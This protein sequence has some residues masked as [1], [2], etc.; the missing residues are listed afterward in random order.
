MK[1]YFLVILISLLN[2]DL[3]SQDRIRARDLGIPFSSSSNP[4]SGL[5]G[6]IDM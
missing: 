5:I 2:F 1:I 3:K 4:A 6:Y